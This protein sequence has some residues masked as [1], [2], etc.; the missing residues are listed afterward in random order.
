MLATMLSYS[1]LDIVDYDRC[2]TNEEKAGQIISRGG[3]HT[4]IASFD[5]FDQCVTPRYY[6]QYCRSKLM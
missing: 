4:I 1:L 6:L 2:A 3:G 5:T